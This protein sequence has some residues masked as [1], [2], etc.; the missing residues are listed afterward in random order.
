MHIGSTNESPGH[1]DDKRHLLCATSFCIV[2]LRSAMQKLEQLVKILAPEEQNFQEDVSI[3]EAI[4]VDKCQRAVD[5]QPPSPL[6]LLIAGPNRSRSLPAALPTWTKEQLEQTQSVECVVLPDEFKPTNSSLQ[7]L[8]VHLNRICA[9]SALR[10]ISQRCCLV[11]CLGEVNAGKTTLMRALMGL[12]PELDGHKREN[13]TTHI[14]ARRMHMHTATG[15]M[16]HPAAPVLVDTPGFFDTDKTL[17]DVALKQSGTM[18]VYLIMVDGKKI[19]RL[20]QHIHDQIVNLVSHEKPVLV[21]LNQMSRYKDY[22]GPAE[23]TK[24]QL[25]AVK[26]LVIKDADGA[27]GPLE[28]CATEFI[29]YDEHLR[30]INVKGLEYVRDWIGH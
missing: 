23:E 12:P 11:G 9:M 25:Q 3:L 8:S 5:V 29:D 18:A 14:A 13:A 22:C 17:K 15:L 10:T 6:G 26:D 1:Q 30:E 20:D 21:C 4:V 19:A 24:K 27:C 2:K 28:V 16:E 7:I